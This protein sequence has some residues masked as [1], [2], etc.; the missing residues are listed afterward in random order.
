MTAVTNGSE[1]IDY[2]HSPYK[3]GSPMNINVSDAD[4]DRNAARLGRQIAR[5]EQALASVEAGYYVTD[6]ELNESPGL[7]K[8]QRAP[9]RHE[10]V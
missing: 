8:I 9:L 7:S 1:Q 10:W 6:D 3:D 5:A 4:P 2:L